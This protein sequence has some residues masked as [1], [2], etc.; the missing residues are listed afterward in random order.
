MKKLATAFALLVP[1]LGIVFFLFYEQANSPLV[2]VEQ[3]SAGAEMPLKTSTNPMRQKIEPVSV[4]MM[5]MA[6][7]QVGESFSLYIP[8]EDRILAGTVQKSHITRAGNE[9]LEGVIQDGAQSFAF[10]I[11]IGRHQTFGS[12]QTSRDRYQL[13]LTEGAGELIAQSTI[14][15]LRDYSEPDYVI[16]ARRETPQIKEK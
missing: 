7:T 1:V 14:Q 13:E 11:T 3:I 15:G 5:D 6:G 9:V 12:I 10:V 16:P 2:P 8:Q 4:S